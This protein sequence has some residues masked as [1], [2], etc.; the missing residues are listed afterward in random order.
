MLLSDVRAAARQTIKPIIIN[1]L[2]IDP[3]V[4]DCTVDQWMKECE[5]YQEQCQF[6]L[7][8]GQKGGNPIG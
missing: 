2:K 4:Y 1:A 5:R 8:Y 3:V 7:V 6:S